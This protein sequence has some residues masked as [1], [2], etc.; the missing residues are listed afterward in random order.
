MK[1]KT[2]TREKPIRKKPI[3]VVGSSIESTN[4]V[5]VSAVEDVMT[6]AEAAAFLR[7]PEDEIKKMADAAKLPARQIAG[8][9]RFLKSALCDW[10][11]EYEPT[12]TKPKSSRDALIEMAGCWRDDETA[13]AMVEEIY[14]ERKR[15][16]VGE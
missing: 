3:L 14:R 2:P 12:E 9:W 4:G 7:A 13:E 10:L 11:S 5:P 8:E 6:L 16:P 1:T 15:H